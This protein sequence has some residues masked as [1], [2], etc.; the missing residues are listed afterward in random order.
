LMLL[1]L[2]IDSKPSSIMPFITFPFHI[3]SYN[4]TC[5]PKLIHVS[6]EIH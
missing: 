5:C 4:T 6:G 3:T 2:T 1:T